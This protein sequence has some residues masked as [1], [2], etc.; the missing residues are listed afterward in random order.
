MFHV[1]DNTNE[2]VQFFFH[3]FV[4]NTMAMGEKGGSN[5]LKCTA[6]LTTLMNLFMIFFFLQNCIIKINKKKVYFIMTINKAQ[7]QT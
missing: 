7:G 5:T 4:K 6:F 3:K 1:P 2:F